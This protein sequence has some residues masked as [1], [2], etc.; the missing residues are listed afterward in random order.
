MEVEAPL[1]ANSPALPLPQL[2]PAR[3]DDY[4]HITRLAIRHNF[5]ITSAD[6][7]RRLWLDNPLWPRLG[8][9]WPIGWVLETTAGEIVGSMGNV[10]L[11]YTFRGQELIAASGRAWSVLAPYRGFALWLLDEHFHQAGVDLYM[12]TS[13]G[14]MALGPFSELCPRIPLGEWDTVS[15]WVTD[16]RAF[17]NNGLQKLAVPL[18]GLLAGPMSAALRLS[19]AIS[20][21]R[22]PKAAAS[23]VIETTDRFDVGFD[24]FW[25][26]LIRQNPETLL[27]DRSSAS[28]SWHFAAPMRKGELRIF[29]ATRNDR[30]RAY[31][32]LKCNPNG[33]GLRRMR[34]IDYQNL[35]SDVDLLPAVLRVALR[36]CAAE[37]YSILESL[38]R[39]VSTMRAFDEFA[40]YRRKL[41]NWQ[42][43]F[44][45][46][47]PALEEALREPRHWAPSSFDGDASLD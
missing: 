5:Q 8:A 7:W 23:V 18:A 34:L 30:L 43:F 15:Y 45:T 27:A 41:P 17:A 11:L 9:D 42:F 1:Q 29:T 31:C 38:G 4:A 47:D 21:K 16:Y 36:R 32:V 44:R 33:R 2:R 35:D 19:E 37:G 26:E 46:N 20:H 10:P 12:E 14:P 24:A 6:D 39:G 28:L 25:E 40:P 13:I 22:L 3:F